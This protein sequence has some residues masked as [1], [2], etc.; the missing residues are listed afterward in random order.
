MLLVTSEE[1][2][3]IHFAIHGLIEKQKYVESFCISCYVLSISFD[4][5]SCNMSCIIWVTDSSVVSYRR[6]SAGQQ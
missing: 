1:F 2:I 5:I 3:R 6:K 4:L